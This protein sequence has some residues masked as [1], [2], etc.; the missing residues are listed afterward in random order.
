MLKVH[1][2]L[3]WKWSYFN[4]L[5]KTKELFRGQKVITMTD[6]VNSVC[7]TFVPCWASKPGHLAHRANIL[8][9]SSTPTFVCSSLSLGYTPTCMYSSL[10]LSSTPTCVCSSLPLSSTP[11][12][13][14]VPYH[15]ATPLP[16][17]IPSYN[18]APPLPVCSAHWS[19]WMKKVLFC[20]YLFPCFFCFCINPWVIAHFKSHG[21]GDWLKGHWF[22]R[23]LEMEP[24]IHPLTPL[25]ITCRGP[26][27]K[28]VLLHLCT[29][30]YNILSFALKHVFD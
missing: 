27:N 30:P 26:N 15:W 23:P 16:V 24:Q 25:A 21:G 29:C 2:I 10:P 4:H 28:R 20:F 6:G 9:L 12:V 22:L 19:L 17:F 1:Y 18:W 8:P 3:A 7:C 14:V 11:P 5:N 13:C